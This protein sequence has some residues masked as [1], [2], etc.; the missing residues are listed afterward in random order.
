MKSGTVS[1]FRL[2]ANVNLLDANQTI[3]GNKTFN[4][5][6]SATDPQ[7]AFGG[8]GSALTGLNAAN[9]D[10]G[11]LADARLSA[12]VNLLNGAQTVTGAKT[13]SANNVFSATNSFGGS[14]HFSGIVV[15]TNAANVIVGDGSGL[16][17]LSG[18]N[19]S[20][21]TVP[22]GRLSGNVVLADGTVNFSSA[23]TGQTP[24]ASG[25]LATKGYV[26]G[27]LTGN[28]TFSGNNVFQGSNHYSGILV[29]TN[30]DNLLVGDGSG[31][32][33]L[34]ASAL[35]GGT[36]SDARLSANVSLLNASQT[37]TGNKTF[38]GTVSATDPQ[39]SFGGDGSALTGLNAAN[40]DN[41]TLADAR[42]SANVSILDTAQTVTGAKTFSAN[43]V[44][45]ATNSF[46]GSNHFSGIVVATNAANV[47][48][49]D[50][51]SLTALSASALASGE[52]ADARLSSNVPLLS[53]GAT[54]SGTVGGTALNIG[55]GNTV[56]GT[57]SSVAGGLGNV[58]S[59]AYSFVGG[60]TNNKVN[61]TIFGPRS[62][63][64]GGTD[65]L[66]QGSDS[67][68][69]GGRSNY[70]QSGT[71]LVTIGGG[72]TN[73][74]L[75][76]SQS[77]VIG[78]GFS[79][80][81]NTGE[82]AVIG[83]G[84]GNNVSGESLYGTV[85]GGR[86]NSV[87]KDY[88]FAAGR[89]AK[90]NHQGAFAWA[91]ST[92]ADFTSS[93]NDT[94]NVR[95]G[96]GVNF[97][98]NTGNFDITSSGT[99]QVNGTDVLL[100]GVAGDGS[101][102]TGLNAGNLASGT[103]P[104]AR[105]SGDVIQKDGSVAFTAVVSGVDP[106]AST[107]LATKSYVDSASGWGLAG[108]AS[109]TGGTS[110]VG[111]TD[112][113]NFEV[114]VNGIQGVRVE[115]RTTTAEAPNFMAGRISSFSNDAGNEGVAI[116]GGENHDVAAS[117][118]F[119]T[120][121]GGDNNDVTGNYSTIGGGN[122][123][124]VTDTSNYSPVG[125]GGGTMPTL[126]ITSRLP[127]A[128]RTLPKVRPPR[129]PGASRTASPTLT[130]RRLRAAMATGSDQPLISRSLAGAAPTSLPVDRSFLRLGAA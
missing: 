66:I 51:S 22:D 70:V 93:A 31:L 94:F 100:D 119:A 58:A 45:S 81:I 86:D 69:G 101:A 50:G 85:P 32:T 9:V 111:T 64:V 120:V 29:A 23:V 108:N 92:D 44:F 17:A 33:E 65:N 129:L 3:T 114:R 25:H 95:A 11:T 16:T 88:G 7:S 112:D 52:V 71:P 125:G 105:L 62:A 20:S 98:L 30:A 42:L 55:S 35:K 72:A 41:G 13:F 82:F 63:I 126:T 123:N 43:N 2:S 110:F 84:Q 24:T 118:D 102:L 10:N 124:T 97:S 12:N 1:D 61:D 103:V 60:G 5:T 75:L 49:G 77:S 80:R 99:V 34:D 56:S 113:Q 59:A 57:G 117:S 107:H 91:D 53:S 6:V 54:F 106:T 67:F 27:T 21:G 48:V 89:R 19:I 76:G 38:S 14:N 15:A 121:G 122:A 78:G 130:R 116:G 73:V 37:I 36:V 115:S 26:D 128:G 18:A 83:G 68:I 4:G 74:V 40:V 47:I 104:T 109:T 79:N 90:V 96:G 46:A 87:T 39:S 8:D 127:V 28:N